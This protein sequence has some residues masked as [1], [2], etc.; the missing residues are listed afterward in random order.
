VAY[1]VTFVH[2]EEQIINT[3]F[4]NE[5][6]EDRPYMVMYIN[7]PRAAGLRS[8]AVHGCRNIHGILYSTFLNFSRL[9][10]GITSTPI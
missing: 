6:V 8:F 9:Q 4:L 5:G 10:T 2:E 1:T 7:S 3:Y